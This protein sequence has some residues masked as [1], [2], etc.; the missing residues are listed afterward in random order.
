MCEE[1]NHKSFVIRQNKCLVLFAL[2]AL[3]VSLKNVDNFDFE[4]SFAIR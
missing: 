4:A 2:L 1:K 3:L